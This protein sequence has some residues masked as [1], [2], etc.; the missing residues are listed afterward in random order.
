MVNLNMTGSRDPDVV[1]TNTSGMRLDVFC[2]P[3]SAADIYDQMTVDQMRSSAY[4][5][6]NNR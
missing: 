5:I 2:H 3:A 1:A 6:V 4:S